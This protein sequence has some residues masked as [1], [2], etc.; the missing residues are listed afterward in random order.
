[1]GYA[2]KAF[3]EAPGEARRPV[4]GLRVAS[5]Q[6]SAADLI[7]QWVDVTLANRPAADAVDT[8][9]RL[10]HPDEAALHAD[11]TRRWRVPPAPP[12]AEVAQARALAAFKRGRIVLLVDNRQVEDAEAKIGIADDTEVTF[13][14]LVPLVGG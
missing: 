11:R 12:C 2:V 13:L 1:M 10:A 4:V 9:A 14:R 7:R 6:V 3:D 8:S 5:R